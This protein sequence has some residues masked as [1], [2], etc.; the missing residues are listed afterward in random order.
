LPRGRSAEKAGRCG[1][2]APHTAPF[3][4]PAGAGPAPAFA[5]PRAALSLGLE[6]ED[7][8]MMSELMM[9]LWS[10]LAQALA[11]RGGRYWLT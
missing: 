6:T 2:E 7:T 8:P 11:A 4:P 5:P 1:L 3:S 10:F 9:T